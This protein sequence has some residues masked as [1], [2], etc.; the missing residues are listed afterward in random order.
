MKKDKI[1]KTI[2]FISLIIFF[3]PQMFKDVLIDIDK[4]YKILKTQLLGYIKLLN[5]VFPAALLHI[6]F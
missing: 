6:F 3:E 4:L 5:K 2:L 1:L